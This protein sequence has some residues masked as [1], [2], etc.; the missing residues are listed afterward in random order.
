MRPNPE[1]VV[2]LVIF[3][4]EILNQKLHFLCSA[5]YDSILLNQVLIFD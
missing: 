2:D 3:T 5:M 4:E 1:K